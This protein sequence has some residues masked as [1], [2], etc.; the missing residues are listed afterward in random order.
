[1]VPKTHRPEDLSGGPLS[2]APP[3]YQPVSHDSTVI[4]S[5][6]DGEEP[7]DSEKE[8]LRRV[9]DRLPISAWFVAVVELAERFSYYGLSGPFRT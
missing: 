9:S 2:V 6:Q 4:T 3:V 5:S 8:A 1:M 7:T